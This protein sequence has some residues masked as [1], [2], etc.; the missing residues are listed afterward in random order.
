VLAS[1]PATLFEAHLFS[2]SSRR[3][4]PLQIK[5][6]LRL[7]L[8]KEE[9]RISWCRYGASH[10]ALRGSMATV[11]MA[12]GA[13]VRDAR[14][15]SAFV[16]VHI[17]KCGGRT[18]LRSSAYFLNL[19]SCG[20]IH[21]PQGATKRVKHEREL[22]RN[23]RCSIIQKELPFSTLS[24]LTG[25]LTQGR[26]VYFLTM[27]REPVYHFISQCIFDHRKNPSI[28]EDAFNSCLR[29]FRGTPLRGSRQL[30]GTLGQ[31]VEAW[32]LWDPQVKMVRTSGE[33]LATTIST[34]HQK[35]LAV[36]VTEHYNL[37]MC[38]FYFQIHNMIPSACKCAEYMGVNRTT[39][40]SVRSRIV[41][42][43]KD[44][45]CTANQLSQLKHY[46]AQDTEMYAQV[47]STLFK[48][49]KALEESSGIRMIC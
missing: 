7:L 46:R 45:S 4:Q 12:S 18:F 39:T 42:R 29:G 16:F 10:L 14:D 23:R 25:D 19:T 37:S 27:L 47:R 24:D 5:I 1:A 2:L 35:F 31:V 49:I 43:T 6:V 33:E 44:A 28:T 26:N 13:P 21:W 40:R 48:R 41:G 9:N 20:Q 36:G 38:F 15:N 30:P 8:V 34:L 3:L 22:L 17:A 32:H 11:P